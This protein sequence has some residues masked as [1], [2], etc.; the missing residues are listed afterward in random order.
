[1]AKK[2]PTTENRVY[3][4][5]SLAGALLDGPAGDLLTSGDNGE[6]E[7]AMR[8]LADIAFVSCVLSDSEDLDAAAVRAR[9]LGAEPPAE[10]KPAPKAAAPKSKAKKPK[11]QKK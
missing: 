6:R 4:F 7:R 9:V 2:E 8:A 5:D 1:M 3:L 10:A 11:S